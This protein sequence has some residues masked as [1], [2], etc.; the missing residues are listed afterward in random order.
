MKNKLARLRALEQVAD[1]Q[2]PSRATAASQTAAEEAARLTIEAAEIQVDLNAAHIEATESAKEISGRIALLKAAY[3]KCCRLKQMALREADRKKASAE[4]GQAA[5]V[6]QKRGQKDQILAE[7]DRF[8][9][10]TWDKSTETD[11]RQFITGLQQSL[12][13][14]PL[15]APGGGGTDAGGSA[16]R[17]VHFGEEEGEPQSAAAPAAAPGVTSHRNLCLFGEDYDQERELELEQEW[18]T[19]GLEETRQFYA[20]T[21]ETIWQEATTAP[22]EDDDSMDGGDSTSDNNVDHLP[23]AVDTGVEGWIKELEANLDAIQKETFELE[24]LAAGIDKTCKRITRS[25]SQLNDFLNITIARKQALHNAKYNVYIPQVFF[26]LYNV[27]PGQRSIPA[28]EGGRSWRE[29]YREVNLPH[30]GRE[31][32]QIT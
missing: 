21:L 30:E 10:L 20:A 19:K 9:S 24:K 2:S 22:N 3:A 4:A 13:I 12:R 32:R 26:I 8:L 7:P 25:E 16:K 5:A 27:F 15:D 28:G 6:L 23:D 29:I 17:K 31:G 14:G 1:K 18:A 11:L